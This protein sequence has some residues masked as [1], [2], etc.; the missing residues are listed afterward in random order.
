MQLIQCFE[1]WTL[2]KGKETPE[3]N[4]KAAA[5]T[6]ARQPWNCCGGWSNF[7]SCKAVRTHGCRLP[8]DALAVANM[9]CSHEEET[10]QICRIFCFEFSH[11]KANK[12][13]F[14]LA[15]GYGEYVFT[16]STGSLQLNVGKAPGFAEIPGHFSDE[17]LAGLDESK[18]KSTS[19]RICA[20]KH[21]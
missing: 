12:V 9:C 16:R 1:F 10:G 17:L 11:L 20:W 21:A 7:D 19:R 14:N 13:T 15:Q 8:I 18:R 3:P 6:A 4:Q 2:W 5:A